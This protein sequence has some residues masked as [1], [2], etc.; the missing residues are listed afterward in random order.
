M[1]IRP[2]AFTLAELLIVMGIIVLFITMAIPAIRALMGSNSASLARNEIA[3]LLTPLAKRPL[4]SRTFA[5]CCS[6]SIQPPIK[7]KGIC[8]AAALQDPAMQGILLLDSMPGP[9]R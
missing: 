7:L 8:Q 4:A 2:K 9:I 6:F 1:K 3:S 5:A